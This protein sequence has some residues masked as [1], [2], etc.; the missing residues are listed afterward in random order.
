M[1]RTL[2][3]GEVLVNPQAAAKLDY[4]DIE[5]ALLRHANCDWGDLCQECMDKNDAAYDNECNILSAYNNPHGPRIG[6]ATLADRSKT[7]LFLW[8]DIKRDAK[9]RILER[10]AQDKK[11]QELK[12]GASPE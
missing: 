2:E 9:K 4:A 6:I 8:D 12:T 5:Y 7:V 1:K 10:K 11:E 3:L